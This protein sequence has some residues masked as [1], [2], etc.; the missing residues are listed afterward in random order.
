MEKLEILTHPDV[1]H[2][3]LWDIF[4]RVYVSRKSYENYRLE[5]AGE[6][7][8]REI[9]PVHLPYIRLSKLLT[10]YETPA[11]TNLEVIGG[12]LSEQKEPL[13]YIGDIFF[14]GLLFKV[15]EGACGHTHGEII[16]CLLYTSRCV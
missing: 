15:Y 9:N 12:T 6:S 13:E 16:F 3:G 8:L 11:L 1:D 10:G 5:K 14:G 4:S 7:N 2:C